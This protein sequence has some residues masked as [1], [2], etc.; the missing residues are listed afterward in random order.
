LSSASSTYGGGTTISGGTVAANE[1]NLGA[2]TGGIT[3]NGGTLAPPAVMN[4]SRSITNSSTGGISA[5]GGAVT[6]QGSGN[7]SWG[8]GAF[9]ISGGT[10]NLSRIGGTVSV[11]AGASIT[12]N[13][14]ATLNL[15]GTVDVLND[16]VSG[17]AVNVINNSTT[18][19]HVSA[20]S[21]HVGN[22]SGI[23]NTLVDSGA[24]LGAKSITQNALT[25][26]NG[27]V[28]VSTPNAAM[29][30]SPDYTPNWTTSI[31]VNSL[32]IG[33]AGGRITVTARTAAAG[34]PADPKAIHNHPLVVGSN[35]AG[36]TLSLGA[37][38]AENGALDLNDHDLIVNYSGVSP[39]TTL[40]AYVLDGLRFP[41]DPSAT[42]GIVSTTGANSTAPAGNI[43]VLFE[44]TVIDG[45]STVALTDTWDGV[46]VDIDTVI[47]KY[48][49]FGDANL[50]GQ[51]NADDYT[52]AD[53]NRAVTAGALWTQGDV[54]L[55]GAVTPDDYTT[56]DSN[57]GQGTDNPLAPQGLSAVPEPAATTMGG[58]G[59]GALLTR[60]ARRNKKGSRGL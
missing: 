32:S 10:V 11:G 23:G 49:Y 7:A 2:A 58:F 3:F 30:V 1:S 4:T 39:L 27:T 41:G 16:T 35:A 31:S 29:L 46:T 53:S 26:S 43:L 51:V 42:A 60:R 14:G 52:T 15:A 22:I 50:D 57:R 9:A 18:T 36:G 12:I 59:L 45:G 40:Q 13:A 56:M 20:G 19:L 21:K 55:D 47:G 8:S 5:A 6:I 33:A 54:N 48:T 25:V 17:N 34:P 37:P 24:T 44:N 28:N 38:G